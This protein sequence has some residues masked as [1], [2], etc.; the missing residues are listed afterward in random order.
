MP[1]GD[2]SSWAAQERHQMSRD[3][4][5]V[6]PHYTDTRLRTRTQS[7]RGDRPMAGLQREQRH[8]GDKSDSQ[9]VTA[10]P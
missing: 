4:P 10:L 9:R 1:I 5:H 2:V 8:D 3:R 6:R 7:P